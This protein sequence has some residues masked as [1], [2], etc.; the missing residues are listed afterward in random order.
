MPSASSLSSSA[1]LEYDKFSDM[2]D[3]TPPFHLYE[4]LMAKEQK[5]LDTLNRFANVKE[6]NVS[7]TT[8]VKDSSVFELIRSIAKTNYEVFRDISNAESITGFQKSLSPDRLVHLGITI[9]AIAVFLVVAMMS[10]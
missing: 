8:S 3:N 4:E 10:T 7:K 5:M 2:L 6:D 9:V 1:Y